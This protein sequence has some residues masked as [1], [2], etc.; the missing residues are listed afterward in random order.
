MVKNTLN[1]KKIKRKRF[2]TSLGAGLLGTAVL[3]R[4][5]F[6]LFMNNTGKAEAA[7]IKVEINP[8]AVN[9]KKIGDKNA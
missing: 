1:L 8:L 6:N 5:P 3:N 7:K 9:R 2:F 4:F